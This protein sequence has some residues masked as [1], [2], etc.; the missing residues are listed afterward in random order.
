MIDLG[1]QITEYIDY[2]T[3]HKKLNHKTTKAYSIDLRQFRDFME[4][5]TDKLSKAALSNY[6]VYL[7]KK[8]KP[9]TVKR[10]VAS[11]KAFL[12]YLEF[13][14]IITDNQFSKLQTR[15]HEPQ[16]LPRT[17]PLRIITKILRAAYK[18]WG[19]A[20]TDFQKKTTLR[21]IAILEFLFAT[22]MRVSEVCSLSEK[23]VNL[24]DGSIR[25]M[26]KGSKE[27]V[28]QIGNSEVISIL[29]QYK[30]AFITQIS[31]D[32][33]FFINRLHTRISEQS[34]RFM[35]KKYS[36]IAG[37]SLHITPHMF[38]HSFATL[39]LEEDVDI[40]YIQQML[41]HS[42]IVT[43]QIYTHV[44][45]KKQKKILALKHPRNKISVGIEP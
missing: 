34:V 14:E 24:F 20:N 31:A 15:F 12:R 18:E 27:R 2:C 40:R 25:V 44:A 22:G 33:H 16:I 26:G 32:G 29:K 43:T 39:L 42:S 19:K 45:S 3:Y 41:G 1:Q 35:I 21:D 7:H 11:L 8:F 23:D 4:A 38:R 30:K 5:K 28:L 37:I 9:K 13:E 10:K 6:I 17:I 36:D